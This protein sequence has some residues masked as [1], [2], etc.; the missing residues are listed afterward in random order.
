[1]NRESEINESI[2]ELIKKLYKIIIESPNKNV[3]DWQ[4]RS[5]RSLALCDIIIIYKLDKLGSRV[6]ILLGLFASCFILLLITLMNLV[7]TK[8]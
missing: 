6:N 5:I 8:H 2:D 3:D 4:T 7:L 1:M